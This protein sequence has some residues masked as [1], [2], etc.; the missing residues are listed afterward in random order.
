MTGITCLG[1][2][3]E[4]DFFL[5]LDLAMAATLISSNAGGGEE[6]Q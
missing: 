1:R 3:S 2:S 6:G 4:I 5:S